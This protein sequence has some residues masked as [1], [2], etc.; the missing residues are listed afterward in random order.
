MQS[1]LVLHVYN[2]V[3]RRLIDGDTFAADISLGFYVALVNR[4]VR[5]AHCNAPEVNTPEGQSA[6]AFV[7]QLM[8]AGTAIV[9]TSK[10]ID[11]YGRILGSIQ[12]ADGRDLATVLIAGGFALPYEGGP[13]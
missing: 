8:P 2:A 13:R 1:N 6:K 10:E 11:K 7:G 3:V 4:T 9:V 12:L 5:L